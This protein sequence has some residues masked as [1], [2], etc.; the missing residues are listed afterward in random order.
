[1]AIITRCYLLP[2]ASPRLLSPQKIFD[3]QNGH[4]GQFW[5]DEDQFHLEYQNKP[6]ISVRYS[7][8][9]NLPTG[10]AISTTDETSS[11]VNLSLVSKE[12]QN[13]TAGQKLL[14]E[15]HYRFGHTNMPLIQ[16]IINDLKLG[17]TISVDHFES[18]LICCTFDSYGKATSDKY[19]GGCIFVDHASGYVH[20]EFQ[21]G[22]SA[23]ETIRAKQ[24]FE[25]FAFNNGV[26]LIT[27]LTDSGAFKANNFVQHLRDRNQKIQY[28]G[29]NAHHQN[30]VAERA[31]R[32]ISNMARGMLLYAP[33]HWK[34]RVDSTM[35]PMAVQYATYVYNI[36]SQSN[37]IS[38]SDLFYGAT[39]PRHKLQNMH[40]RGCPVYVLNPTLQAGKIPRW[41]P[42][43]KRGVFCG[44]S[45]V[46]SSE[47]PQV[48]NLTTG[49]ITTQFYVVFDDLF[50]IVHSVE[51]E[52]EPPSQWQ[53]L[54]LEQTE[55][56]PIDTPPP[57]SP[58]WLV[59]SDS[60][61]SGRTETRTNRVRQDLSIPAQQQM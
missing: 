28:C 12:N 2:S 46:H 47:V 22:F 39:V 14:L 30:G 59:E 36:L 19:I 23:I 44:L 1:M 7:T 40:V 6:P 25:K 41:E 4:P 3:K 55:Y 42:R 17:A 31:I 26:I 27:Y 49:S 8:E 53:D 29:T 38:P 16:Q 5:G 33:A 50:T 10:Y 56:I 43:S 35:W 61:G 52:E 37:N 21:L 60:L 20:V 15:Y 48:L 13:L 34:H 11:Q 58:E 24:N 45:T 51:R 54:C 9:S 32:T 57:L 18:R